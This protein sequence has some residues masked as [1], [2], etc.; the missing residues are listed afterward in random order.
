[1]RPRTWVKPRSRTTIYEYTHQK[2]W[3]PQVEFSQLGATRDFAGWRRLSY[4]AVLSLACQCAP[5]SRSVRFP[6]DPALV[7][8]L[9]DTI[10]DSPGLPPVVVPDV[11]SRALPAIFDP[12]IA[13][14][15]WSWPWAAPASSAPSV[16]GARPTDPDGRTTH[17]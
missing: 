3:L 10:D 12:I 8:I 15:T 5:A 7:A 11:V 14:R 16:V 13:N 6:R 4:P 1:S 17:V 9:I 2:S